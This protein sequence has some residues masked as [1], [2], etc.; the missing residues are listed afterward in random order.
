MIQPEICHIIGM[1]VFDVY[2]YYIQNTHTNNLL[3]HLSPSPQKYHPV[4]MIWWMSNWCA[5]STGSAD[6]ATGDLKDSKN[7]TMCW[8]RKFI[9]LLLAVAR[10]KKSWVGHQQE[11]FWH[12]VNDVEKYPNAESGRMIFWQMIPTSVL[13]YRRICKQNFKQIHAIL[14]EES[15]NWE[16][17]DGSYGG[18]PMVAVSSATAGLIVHIV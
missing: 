4:W 11:T 9:R 12:D 1:Y 8:T 5:P 16:S 13:Q 14:R 2:I 6:P 7:M 15:K 17:S 18:T 3:Y 10:Q